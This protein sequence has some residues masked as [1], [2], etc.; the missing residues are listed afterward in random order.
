MKA[1][2]VTGKRPNFERIKQLVLDGYIS[3]R[4]HPEDESLVIHN[5]TP[6]TQ[7]D[8][9][10]NDQTLMC[11]GLISRNE[12]VVARPFSKFFNY[13]EFSKAHSNILKGPWH[14]AEKMDGSLGILYEFAP[15]DFR[16][17]T[18]GSFSSP[19]ALVATQ[20]LKSKY[21]D[22]RPFTG[23]TWLFEII[24]P[25]NR[26]VLDYEAREE[27]V[28]LD[29]L[30]ADTGG[31][32]YVSDDSHPFSCAEYFGATDDFN[33]DSHANK[34]GYVLTNNSGF[35]VK[36]KFEEYVRLHKIITGCSTR[37]VWEYLKDGLSFDELLSNV[38][39]EFYSWLNATKK[40]LQDEFSSIEDGA[41]E[42]FQ[43]KPSTE[44]RKELAGYF[45][46]YEYPFL[47]FSMMDQK[48]YS[49]KI[50]KMIK[51]ERALP[52]LMQPEEDIEVRL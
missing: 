13:S 14:V 40:Q 25:E 24:Y 32:M 5:Y 50:W 20:W 26:I 21:K 28:L 41:K 7:Y 34:E 36:V 8:K 51:P 3:E 39:D 37:M 30:C 27:L 52:Y 35:R 42:Y 10:W 47:C 23:H 12:K 18:R 1:T 45:S 29:V 15:D 33:F 17:A 16:I 46:K 48:D 4:L 49:E 19:Q 6:K 38:P 43:N 9:Y 22:F 2:N 11:R 31:R 44:N